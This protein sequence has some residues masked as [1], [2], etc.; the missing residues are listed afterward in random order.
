LLFPYSTP[1]YWTASYF[2]AAGP[3]ESTPGPVPKPGPYWASAFFGGSGLLILGG[4]APALPSAASGLTDGLV[5]Q[6]L[7]AL[8]DGLGVFA[9]VVVGRLAQPQALGEY[10]LARV[11]PIA[12]KESDDWDPVELARV[13]TVEILIEIRPDDP[14][15]ELGAM[16]SLDA[17]SNLVADALSL[18]PVEDEILGLSRLLG[19][20]YPARDARDS[21]FGVSTRWEIAYLVEGRAGRSVGS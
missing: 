4:E 10:P 9:G 11:Y 15:D 20:T 8:L 2:A 6:S 17:L 5:V 7:A 3:G 16:L 12:F 1:G 18:S 21:T 13:L 19:G 14:A